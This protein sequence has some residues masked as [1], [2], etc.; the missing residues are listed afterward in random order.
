LSDLSLVPQNAGVDDHLSPAMLYHHLMEA[1]LA[2]AQTG[3][4]GDTDIR[5]ARYFD[6]LRDRGKGWWQADLGSYRDYLTDR[7]L[8]ASTIR[9]YL[10]STRRG[11]RRLVLDRDLLYAFA[12]ANAPPER[13]KAIVDEIE[14]RLRIAADPEKSR[15]SGITVQDYDSREEIRLSRQQ[16]QRLLRQPGI[17]TLQGLRDTA[18]IAMMLCTGVREAELVNI[19][20]DDLH[21]RLGDELALRVRRGKGAKQRL[22][23][24]GQLAWV[25]DIVRVWL[26]QAGITSGPVFR[27]VYKGGQ[28][29]RN[30]AL[31]TRAVRAIM[32]RYEVTVDGTDTTIRPHDLRRTYA[33][34]MFE[35]GVE[36]LAIQQNLGHRKQETT[37]HY[38]GE[39]HGDQRRA[40]ELYD[41]DFEDGDRPE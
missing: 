9:A 34:R 25:L 29:V 30:T 12:P 16:A 15:V 36:L 13:R 22:I 28:S 27:G 5:I 41:F 8:A 14:T 35:A 39:L 11:L 19:Y 18:L 31:T 21:A 2:A 40:P 23:P 20:V 32:K 26:R 24:Y 1:G 10:S 37:E 4:S 6:F 3:D 7:G 33:R 17:D 38:I